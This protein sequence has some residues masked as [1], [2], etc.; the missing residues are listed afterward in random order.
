MANMATLQAKDFT[1]PIRIGRKHF[2]ADAVYPFRFREYIK[3]AKDKKRKNDQP[4]HFSKERVKHGQTKI[5]E[6]QSN[7]DGPSPWSSLSSP[8]R[9]IPK[10][11]HGSTKITW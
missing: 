5:Y 8:K 10:Q 11:S 1:I 6:R 4:K 2:T 3:Y 9:K 7:D